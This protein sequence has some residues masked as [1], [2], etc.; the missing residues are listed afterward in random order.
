MKK[1]IATVF[2]LCFYCQLA[3]AIPPADRKMTKGTIFNYAIKEGAISYTV[4]VTVTEWDE[5]LNIKLQWQASGGKTFKGGCVQP[6]SSIIYATKMMIALKAGDETLPGD[7][8]RWF[9]GYENYDLLYNDD[10]DADMK[11]DDKSTSFEP[12]ATAVEKKILYNNVK[13]T[14]N[15]AGGKNSSSA[16]PITIGF[17]EYADKVI[18][19]DN[20]TNGN[21]S[22]RLLSIQNPV[23]KQVAEINKLAEDMTKDLLK[24]I[25]PKGTVPLKKMEAAKFAKVKTSYPL[26]ATIENYDGTNGSKIK[27]PITETYEFRY[28][29]KAPNPP[30]M[31][32]CFTSDIQILYNQKNN[33]GIVASESIA[34]KSLPSATAKKILEV[35]L[36][37]E[38][39][40]I[41]GYRP[42][43]H[44]RFVKGLTESQR[45]QLATELEGYISQYGFTE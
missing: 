1:I 37:Y 45:E 30:S 19:L 43:T 4:K 34:N 29:N 13:T 32:D 27:K 21:F 15:Y 16:T 7:C 23:A 17:I 9:A 25:A 2:V 36:N 40:K 41:P 38:Y 22:I 12:D 5:D 42:W 39:N 3:H 33:Y 31:I 44:W 20:Y 26:L 6:H 11:I 18:L 35:Y 28:V 24:T 8:S 10:S 14:M